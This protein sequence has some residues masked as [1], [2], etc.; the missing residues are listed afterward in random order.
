MTPLISIIIPTFNRL[1]EI[2]RAIDSITLQT[3]KNWEII[4]VDNN[5]DDGTSDFIEKMNNKKIRLFSIQNNGIIALS[6]NLGISKAQGK[7]VAFLDSD[8]WWEPSKLEVC[9]EYLNNGAN[10]VYHDLYRVKKINQFLNFSKLKTRSMSPPIFDDLI[11]N[12]WA[13]CNSSVVVLRSLLV[14]IG[15]IS[16]NKKLVGCEDYDAWLKISQITE[17]FVRIPKTLGYYW[18]GGGNTSNPTRSLNNLAEIERIYK[19]QF[20]NFRLMDTFY[21]LYYIK[22]RLSFLI[23]KYDLSKSNLKIVLSKKIPFKIYFN[24]QIMRALILLKNK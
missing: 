18:D 7:Y 24:C 13:L 21:Y 1:N 20:D 23:G 22:G 4:V 17:K 12:G 3:F 15:G 16:V 6:R 9:L 11:L 2:I 5:S 8:D 10:V 14:E 19:H